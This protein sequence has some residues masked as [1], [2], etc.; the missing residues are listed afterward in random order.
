[1]HWPVARGTEA[2]RA[3]NYG[4]SSVQDLGPGLRETI[5]AL[6][7]GLENGAG[8]PHCGNRKP[9]TDAMTLA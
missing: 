9:R 7:D 4:C 5:D 8:R 3:D 6:H 2:I 1:M